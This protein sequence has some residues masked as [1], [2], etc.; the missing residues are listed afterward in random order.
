MVKRSG[1]SYGNTLAIVAN[2]PYVRNDLIVPTEPCSIL[3][4]RSCDKTFCNRD[5]PYIRD[6]HMKTRLDIYGHLQANSVTSWRT[7]EYH[8]N[9]SHLR[10]LKEN[11][12]LVSHLWRDQ[13]VACLGKERQQLCYFWKRLKQTKTLEL[14]FL[15]FWRLKRTK[16]D[17]VQRVYKG[18][19]YWL[20]SF[21][22]CLLGLILLTKFSRKRCS[23]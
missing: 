12:T 10:N 20:G 19:T 15:K 5:D 17:A 11:V 8:V 23:T 18:I 7:H 13:L 14:P 2:D 16:V 1:R 9:I 6:D 3:A 4:S 22:E 21:L